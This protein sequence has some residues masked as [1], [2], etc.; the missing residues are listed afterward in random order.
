MR[1]YTTADVA[2]L[3]GL[4]TRQAREYGRSGILDPARDDVGRYLFSFQDLVLLRTAKALLDARVPQRRILRSLERLKEQ[5]PTGRSLTEVRIAAEG[6]EVV[7]Y[8]EGRSWEPESG[9]LRFTFDVAELAARVEP[10]ARRA[11]EESG[12]RA[13]LDEWL[14]LGMQLEVQAPAQAKRAYARVLELQ[15]DHAE[16]LVNLGRLLQ[17]EGEVEEAAVLYARA[18]E[19]SGGDQSTAAFNLGV[20]LEDLGRLDE[21]ARAYRRAIEADPAF[22]DAHY[23]LSRLLEREGDKLSALRHLKSYRALTAPGR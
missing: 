16:A 6:D 7:V 10:L 22:A 13:S 23:N 4:T 1:G 21:A 14:E 17:E 9:Q 8:D 18:L 11:V 3:V 19:A 2:A 20:A 12:G 15:P 5:L